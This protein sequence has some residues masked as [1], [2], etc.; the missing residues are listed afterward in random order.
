MAAPKTN[1][2]EVKSRPPR[3]FVFLD[4]LSIAGDPLDGV[5]LFSP[6]YPRPGRYVG[7]VEALQRV[8][9]VTILLITTV[10]SS[11]RFADFI[12]NR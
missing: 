9:F 11:S 7:E 1:V 4:F 2:A 8:P 12:D 10:A 5:A 6:H 3:C